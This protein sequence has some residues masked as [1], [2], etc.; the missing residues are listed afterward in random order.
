MGLDSQRIAE[1]L[2]M[3][4]ATDPRMAEAARRH[5]PPEPRIRPRGYET[6]LR[7]IVSQQVSTAAAASIWR[8]LETQVGDLHLPERL[9][10]VSPDE[11]RAAGLS[12]MK[13]SYAQSLAGH[14]VDGSLPLDA[15]PEDDEEAIRLLSSVRGLGRWSAEIY[16]LFAEGR[17]D[18]FPA[19]DLAV[20]VQAGRMFGDGSRPSEKRLRDMAEIW[21]PHRGVAALFLWHCYNAP[22]L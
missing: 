4:S 19:G 18:V 17:A 6:L 16:L 22:P 20:Q 21:R 14:V 10:A 9:I 13:A 1:A 11:L 8:K 12:R 15:L 7:A 3:L 5:G 2:A